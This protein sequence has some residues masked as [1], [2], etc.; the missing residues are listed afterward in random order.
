M[1][2]PWAVPSN[3]ME[4]VI[5]NIGRQFGS[6][7]KSVARVLGEKL[8]IPVYD[9]ELITK[10]AEES[11]FS[12]EIF[13]NRDEKKRMLNIGNI[14]GSNR[15]GNY[16]DGLNDSEVFRIQSEVIRKIALEGSAIFVGR[17]SDYVLRD[18]ECLDVFITAPLDVRIARLS[19]KRGITVEQAEI[20]VKKMDKEREN[21]YNFYTF[22]RWG[23]AGTYDLCLDASLLGVEQAAELII[24]FGKKSKLI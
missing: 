9:D 22:G 4:K 13:L 19:E 18:M 6:G 2:R 16:S 21:Y 15:Y 1:H 20:L 12:P 17:A 7:G 14:F 8:G 24:E 23:V 11:G 5:I 3:N 10:A